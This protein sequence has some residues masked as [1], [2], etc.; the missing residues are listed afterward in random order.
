[1]VKFV[2]DQRSIIF[3]YNTVQRLLCGDFFHF[4]SLDRFRT[5]LENFDKN[6]PLIGLGT[7]NWY[8]RNGEVIVDRAAA[9]PSFLWAD[10][11]GLRT[12]TILHLMQD[13]PS[14]LQDLKSPYVGEENDKVPQFPF[15]AMAV[16]NPADVRKFFIPA[17]ANLHQFIKN[18]CS[19]ENIGLAALKIEGAFEQ[20]QYTAAC[21]LPLEA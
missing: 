18:Q 15:L 17:G 20:V 4:S 2:S 8:R 5:D 19:T 9:N 21:Y 7:T 11:E 14:H 1:M 10:P 12:G 6:W 13:I 3:S 16:C